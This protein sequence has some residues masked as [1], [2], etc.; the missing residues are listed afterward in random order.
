ME[1]WETS[2]GCWD[3]ALLSRRPFHHLVSL[4]YVPSLLYVVTNCLV[5]SVRVC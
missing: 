3:G 2:R 4:I 1:N 5:D